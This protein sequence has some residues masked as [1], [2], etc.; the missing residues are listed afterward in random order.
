VFEYFAQVV[1]DML[2]FYATAFAIFTT[3]E[4]MVPV[5]AMTIRD[6][7]RGL[8]FIGLF[9]FVDA[10]TI[11]LVDRAVQVGGLH[12][13]L[14]WRPNLASGI[15]AAIV[16]AAWAD[17]CFYWF[18]RLQH[19]FLWRWH[20]V[21]HS[22]RH[23]SAINAFHHW[24]EPL[25]RTLFVGGPLLLF[26]VRPVG[27]LAPLFFIFRLQQFYIH[28]PNRLQLGRLRM[29]LVDAR[30]HRIHHSVEPRHHDR[31]F[32]AML[33]LWDWL[34]GTLHIPAKDEWPNVGLPQVDEPKNVTEW[35]KF[36]RTFKG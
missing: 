12:N 1:L 18:H 21:H 5:G 22:V 26:D 6:R 36:P 30:F 17:F 2:L 7:T 33:P 8:P 27:I 34:F 20:A 9:I 15:A 29:L 35:S 28:S 11:I 25:W 3:L 23:L 32:A 19:R 10:A 4:V 14:V 31:N 16:A 13:L 24:T